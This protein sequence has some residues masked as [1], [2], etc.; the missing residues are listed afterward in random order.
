MPAVNPFTLRCYTLEAALPKSWWWILGR[1]EILVW[2][3]WDPLQIR[4]SAPILCTFMVEILCCLSMGAL[5]LSGCSP[6]TGTSRPVHRFD[7]QSCLGHLVD[8]MQRGWIVT[9]KTTGRDKWQSVIGQSEYCLGS[10]AAWASTS[11]KGI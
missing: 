6:G 2:Y 3:E 8:L 4:E 11:V 10:P 5:S 7:F 9:Q 1:V